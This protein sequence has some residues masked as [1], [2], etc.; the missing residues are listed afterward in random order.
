MIK[1]SLLLFLIL[2]SNFSF[3]N[4]SNEEVIS[5]N[6]PD[7]KETPKSK[8]INQIVYSVKNK[9]GIDLKVNAEQRYSEKNEL[10]ALELGLTNMVIISSTSLVQKYGLKNYDIFELP[11]IFNDLNSFNK[12]NN[13]LIAEDLL[14]EINNKNKNLYGLSFWA[15][16]YKQ[17]ESSNSIKTYKDILNNS[18]VLENT[19]IN[20]K[21]K[22]L[23]NEKVTNNMDL[24]DLKEDKDNNLNKK[25]IY[26]TMLSLSDAEK[27]GFFNS[28]YK[29][30]L[31][32]YQNLDID[33]ILVNKRWFNKLNPE[34]QLG[35]IDIVRTM[36]IYQQSLM[37]RNN[38]QIIN[39][40]QSKGIK[41]D[42]ISLEERKVF[43]KEIAP[44]HSF[45]YNNI[46]NDL[47]T[48]IYKVQQ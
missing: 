30:V 48:K 10:E 37:I 20:R 29:N 46:N 44:I 23:L 35:I 34:T 31:L 15:K 2:F 33:V 36:G 6:S 5:I 26:S 22:L 1:K 38:A 40:L 19:E 3:A 32:T 16:D 11:F 4:T 17:I 9:Y 14:R 24:D 21:F 18:F 43:K 42:S 47:L 8:A 28:G 13:S 45:F 27:N 7:I 12:F 41:V 25:I 39:Q